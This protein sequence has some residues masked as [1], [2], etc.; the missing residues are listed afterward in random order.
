MNFKCVRPSQP[1]ASGACCRMCSHSVQV[2]AAAAD[3]KP[4]VRR[5]FQKE[6]LTNSMSVCLSAFQGGLLSCTHAEV[7]Q[8]VLQPVTRNKRGGVVR[9]GGGLGRGRV[10]STRG[11]RQ[12]RVG[13]PV[14]GFRRIR[15]APNSNS[16]SM[17]LFVTVQVFRRLYRHEAIMCGVSRKT[18]FPLITAP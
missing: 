4:N 17:W 16:G 13:K 10:G 6:A 15:E 18:R 7:L 11:G 5:Y 2:E 12:T 8:S 1:E 3:S 9:G 14:E